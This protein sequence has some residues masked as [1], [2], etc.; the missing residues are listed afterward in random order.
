MCRY[1]QQFKAFSFPILSMLFNL[2]H[3]K[4]QALDTVLDTGNVKLNKTQLYSQETKQ[5]Q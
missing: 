3:F 2:L 4:C 5:L 1:S